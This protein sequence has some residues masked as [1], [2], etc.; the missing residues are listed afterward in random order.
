MGRDK[1]LTVQIKKLPSLIKETR[2]IKSRGT[3]LIVPI[4]GTSLLINEENPRPFPTNFKKAS[5]KCGS[6]HVTYQAYTIPDSLQRTD[7]YSLF[8]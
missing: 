7:N 6:L 8:H 4:Q 5:Q 2:V 3:T 1:E